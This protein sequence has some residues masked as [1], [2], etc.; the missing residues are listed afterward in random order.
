MSPNEIRLLEM[1]INKQT[2]YHNEIPPDLYDAL[3]IFRRS[4]LIKVQITGW[5]EAALEHE[6]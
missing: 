6:A 2:L 3:R 4:G 5:D 1:F